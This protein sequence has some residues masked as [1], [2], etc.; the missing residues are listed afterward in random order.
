[1]VSLE[2]PAEDAP[3]PIADDDWEPP[4]TLEERLKYALVPPRLYMR[5]LAARAMRKGEPELR[6]LPILADRRKASIDI[7]ANKGVYTYHLARL[8]R[9]VHAFEPNP[10][11][12]RIL[13]RALPPNVTAYKVALSDRSGDDALIVPA[14]KGG[15]SNQGASLA[16]NKLAQPNRT[17]R[18]VTARLDDYDLRNI[19]FIKIDVEGHE[20]A[21]LDGAA[22]TLRR[23]RPVLLIEVEEAHTGE[24]IETSLGHIESFGY[25]GL[26][27]SA[28]RMETLARF[29]P[30]IH[31]RK[32]AAP[33]TYVFNFI[34][35]PTG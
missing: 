21:V 11:I 24:S 14:R 20:R 25:D 18:V 28:G 3:P 26:F 16:R 2:K 17:T 7:G 8:T 15:Y 23:E 9:E 31:H 1:M 22:E 30:E 29:N 5:R 19:G 35:L 33:D 12:F 6:L 10:K 13:N 27:L 34:F 4:Y 32:A